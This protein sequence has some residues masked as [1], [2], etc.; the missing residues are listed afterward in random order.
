MD[1]YYPSIFWKSK[2]KSAKEKGYQGTD[3]NTSFSTKK[4]AR[5]EAQRRIKEFKTNNPTHA[6]HIRFSA[7]IATKRRQFL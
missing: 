1:K 7:H 3:Y 2:Y 6:K 4:E 5:A